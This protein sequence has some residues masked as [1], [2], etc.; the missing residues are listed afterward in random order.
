M[1]Q[2]YSLALKLGA[3]AVAAGAAI[4]FGIDP[5]PWIKS[6]LGSVTTPVLP[7]TPASMISLFF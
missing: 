2:K 1:E 5:T 3:A 7:T 6:L 4:Y